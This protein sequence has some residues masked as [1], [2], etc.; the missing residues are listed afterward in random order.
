MI[1]NLNELIFI[2]RY[3][4]VLFLTVFRYFRWPFDIE[5]VDVIGVLQS[6]Y[7]DINIPI[8]TF[9]VISTVIYLTENLYTYIYI[10]SYIYVFI[11]VTR[12]Q[13]GWTFP[14][15]LLS[16]YIFSQF[17]WICCNWPQGVSLCV[18]LSMCVISIA[19]TDGPILIKLSTNQLL[20]IC[21]I[22]FSPILKI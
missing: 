13:K 6:Q 11:T 10:H 20:Y 3:S 12:N 17:D 2:F 15:S 18:C 9:S 19:Q 21:S 22:C 8:F 16:F 7:D 14:F 4:I 1:R 5:D